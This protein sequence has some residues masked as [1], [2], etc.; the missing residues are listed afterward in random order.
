M[1]RSPPRAG[2]NGGQWAYPQSLAGWGF[3]GLDDVK[4]GDLVSFPMSGLMGTSTVYGHVAYVAMVFA[5]GS[6][7]T[8]NYGDGRYFVEYLSA[9]D[10]QQW[11]PSHGI[12]VRTHP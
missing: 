9:A 11:I 3:G 10:L 1:G 7:V 2:G 5:D 8:E 12:V 6:I 4:A